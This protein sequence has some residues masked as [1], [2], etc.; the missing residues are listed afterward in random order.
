[1]DVDVRK[2]LDFQIKERIVKLAGACFWYWDGFHSFLLSSG[3]HRRLLT[4]F[5]KGTFSKYQVMRNILDELEISSD[6][7]IIENIVSSFYRLTTPIDRDNLDVNEAKQLLKDFKAAVGDDPIQ[8]AL[9]EKERQKRQKE[10]KQRGERTQTQLKRLEE[11]K[12]HF[13]SVFS[14]GDYTPQQKGFE[15][16]KIFFDLLDLEELE[17]TKPY[18]GSGEQ[19]DGHFSYAKFDY[20]VEIKWLKGQVKQSDLSIFDGKIRG[21]AQS[22]RGFFLAV[23]GFDDNAIRKYTGDSPRIILMDGQELINVLE[24]R[25][26]FFDSLKYKVDALVRFGDI[27]RK[28]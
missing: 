3:V 6:V 16:E 26:S 12:K 28:G 18:R 2:K 17:Y 14:G 13:L 25:K 27:Y 9:Q 5:P 1:M 22:T 19:I 10:A 23:N 8:R 20:L 15:L 11:I 4:K 7:E 21:K 24:G